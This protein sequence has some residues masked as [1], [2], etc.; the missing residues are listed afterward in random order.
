[1]GT[2][3]TLTVTPA[4]GYSLGSLKYND[5]S[6]HTITGTSF[7][8]P[9]ANVTV[10]GTFT[11]VSSDG[12]ITPP[13][14]VYIQPGTFQMG[15][16][17]VAEPVHSVTISRGFYMGKYE[18]T[19]GEFDA[20]MGSQIGSSFYGKGANYPVYDVSWYH[21]I[22]YCN[23][24]SIAEGLTPAYSVSGISDWAGLTYASIPVRVNSTW[25]AT[26]CDWDA[27]GYRLPTEAEWE[28]ACRAGTTTMFNNGKDTIN[29]SEANFEPYNNVYDENPTA[30]SIGKTT[31]VG[32]YAP[33][34]WGLYDMHG[35][36]WE[37]CWDWY[38]TYASG[39]QTDPS[40]AASGSYRMLRSGSWG[41]YAHALRS[42]YRSSSDPLG[43]WYIFGILGV[44]LVRNAE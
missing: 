8:M 32:S 20:V 2:T 27:T 43:R 44:R 10:S 25:D 39:S 38:G 19:Q 4:S 5:G 17:G 23:K 21:A 7:T 15:Q 26:A 13:E 29:H 37:W 11:A 9:A 22:A 30:T 16:T 14:M 24:L 18:V 33:N 3:I 34:A 42:A 6:D 41:S 36:V 1:V 40:G 31:P 28:Y 12:T 35:N